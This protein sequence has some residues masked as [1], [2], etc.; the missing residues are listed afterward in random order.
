MSIHIKLNP[1]T[2]IPLLVFQVVF[3]S[4]RGSSEYDIAVDNVIVSLG[5][6]DGERKCFELCQSG[7]S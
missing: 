1:S 6:C 7:I 4:E 5:A 3:V 2:L